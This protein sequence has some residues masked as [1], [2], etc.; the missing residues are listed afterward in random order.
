M[1]TTTGATSSTV[2]ST[3]APTRRIKSRTTLDI[4]AE[5]VIASGDDVALRR[6][7]DGTWRSST[8][9][10]WDRAAREIAGGLVELGVGLGDRVV[11]LATTRAEWV[12]ADVGILMAGAVTVPIY[13]SNTPEQCEYIITDSGAE[14]VIVEDPHQLE[15]LYHADVRDKLGAVTKVIYM[16]DVARLEK[17]DREGRTSP[18]LDD[19][20]PEGSDG[21]WLLA[22][23][24][25]RQRGVAWLD[26]NDGKLAEIDA[27]VLPSQTFTIVYTSGTTGPPKGVV[28]SHN[29]MSFTCEAIRDLLELSAEDEQLMFLPL[30]HIFAKILEWA[31]ITVGASIAFAESITQ[32]VANLQEVKPTFMGAVPRVYE[33][34]YVKIQSNFAEKRKKAVPR[35]LINWALKQGKRRSRA[36]CAGQPATDLSIRLADKLVFSKVQATFGGRLRFFISGGAPLAGDIAAFFHQSGILVLEGYGL[37]ETTAVCNVNRPSSY[38]F[39]TVGPAIPGVEI[40]IAEDGE[41]LMR[42]GNIMKG[43]HNNPEA[44]AEALDADGWFHSGDVGV[45]DDDGKLRITDRKKDLIVTAGGKNVAPQNIEN[46]LKALCPYLSQVMVYGDKRKYLSALLTLSDDNV[47]A[48]ASEQ[49]ITATGLAELSANGEVAKLISGYV[50]ELNSKLASYETIKKYKILPHDFDQE[51]G[52]LTP[53]LKVRRKFCTE[54]YGD[55]LA[56]F[57]P[58]DDSS[59][60]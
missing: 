12:E 17:P 58:T 42:G 4:F 35:T 49:G 1:E 27:R 45:I 57:Y 39:G 43:Y 11:I 28:L 19:V 59:S 31:S 24:E 5:R 20:L 47:Q 37:T 55:L 46:S 29:N 22:L 60:L 18:T 9:K 40:R 38:R 16:A 13:P 34:A 30:A 36:L 14:V 41:V 48:W 23:A 52:E 6:K 3:E 26:D 53:T 8:W 25:L 51:T 44:T 7:I 21:D 50:D 2:D 33:K 54:K 32:L 15:K 56:G 10:E